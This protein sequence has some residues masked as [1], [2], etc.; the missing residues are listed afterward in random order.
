MKNLFRKI[1]LPIAVFALAVFGALQTNAMNQKN[2]MVFPQTGYI[3]LDDEK[4]CDV[5]VECFTF[6]GPVCQHL[7]QTAWGKFNPTDMQCPIPLSRVPQ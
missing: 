4:P 6:G 2:K 5:A 1:G 3:T 7:S